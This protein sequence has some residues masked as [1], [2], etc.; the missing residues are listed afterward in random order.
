[1]NEWW[2][3][4][5]IWRLSLRQA[6][7]VGLVPVLWPVILPVVLIRRARRQAGAGTSA[8]GASEGTGGRS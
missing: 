6:L 1:M 5:T 3:V 8:V 2:L 7:V 4:A